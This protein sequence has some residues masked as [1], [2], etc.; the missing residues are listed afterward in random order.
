MIPPPR[1]IGKVP[2]GMAGQGFDDRAGQ[3]ALAPVGLGID[4]V[5]GVAGPQH[6]QEVQPAL[7]GGEG[8]E[9]IVANLC[10]VA[11]LVPV[12]GA[13]VID[14][15]PGRRFQPGPQ[16]GVLDEGAGVRVEPT[17][18]LEITMPIARSW[19][20][21]RGMVTWPWYCSSTKRR[22]S[23][24]KWP[25]PAS[26]PSR[27]RREDGLPVGREPA[28][29]ADAPDMRAQHQILDDEVLVALEAR[30]GRHVDLD[31]ALLINDQLHQ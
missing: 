17:W 20:T 15:D 26:A 4:H 13:G 23:G 28:L 19:P 24:P 7:R 16:H 21:R 18:R 30:P 6:F 3:S 14:A 31:D 5:I 12:A 25:Q 22:S 9:V 29:P 8:G 1:L 2:V 10:A 27:H 11:V